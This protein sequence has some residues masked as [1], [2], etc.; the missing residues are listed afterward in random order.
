MWVC[1]ETA[2]QWSLNMSTATLI[3]KPEVVR[4]FARRLHY[5]RTA[6]GLTQRVLADRAGL[7]QGAI[8]H[9]ER[10]HTDI[11]LPTLHRVAYGAGTTVTWLAELSEPGEREVVPPKRAPGGA[12]LDSDGLRIDFAIRLRAGRL[13]RGLT[14][15]E[16]AERA[17]IWKRTEIS[18]ELVEKTPHLTPVHQLAVALELPVGWLLE[19]GPNP[20]GS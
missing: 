4:S 19:G 12:V 2:R 9:L 18:Y 17:G 15:R 3:D 14:Q 16:L 11:L 20:W 13:A 10:G 8:S 7:K 6:G 5:A 1:L